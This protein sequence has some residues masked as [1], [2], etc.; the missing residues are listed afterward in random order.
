L[1]V[2]NRR[3]EGNQLDIAIGV[4]VLVVAALLGV[5]AL[6]DLSGLKRWNQPPRETLNDVLER[7]R[8][9]KH[10]RPF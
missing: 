2:S 5:F 8:A 4:G 3:P 10:G 6:V 1:G 7:E 9:N